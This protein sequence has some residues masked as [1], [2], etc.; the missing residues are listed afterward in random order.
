[1]NQPTLIQQAYRFALAP[2]PGQEGFLSACCGASRFWFNQ[3]LSLVKHRLEQ[4]AADQNVDVP[5][6]YQSLCVVFRGTAIKDH[7]APW[8]GEVVI[9]SYQ[10]GLEALGAA[11]RRF[12]EGRRA[13]RGVGF[14]RFR[15]KGR[16]HESVIFQQPRIL[17]ARHICLDKKRLGPIKTKE[18]LRKLTRLLARDERA[19]VVRATVQ[20]GG[21]GWVISFTV[22]RS[23]KLRRARRPT[24]AVGVDMGL[25][26]LATLSTGQVAP[27]SRPL[28]E[29]LV[30]LRRLQRRLDR[31]RRAANPGNY[32]PDGRIKPAR[33]AWAKSARMVRTEE[34]IRRL[35]ERVAN[36]RREQAHQLT[37]LLTREFGVIGVETLAVKNMLRNRR[38]ARHISDV[39]WGAILAQLA[40]KSSWSGGSILV[41]ADRFHPSSKTCSACGAVRAKLSLAERV[42]TCDD[43]AC[44]HVQDRDLNA[45]LNLAHMAARHAQ[46]E[47]LQCHVAATGAETRNARGGQVSLDPVEHSPAKREGPSGSSQRG[48]ALALA[49]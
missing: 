34:R 39:G 43:S 21:G 23:P 48:H 19:R 27:N 31:Q 7:V 12:S 1:M 44:G 9:G 8:R 32:L 24:A 41:A 37:T 3:G 26:R 22:E 2:T 15:A 45:A 20:R 36:L 17:D 35:H 29:V 16:C 46:A 18:S 30:R 10:A 47:G 14:P 25:A 40:Y 28:R 4:R 49:A 11:L 5:W 6:S 13:G 42:F 38:L 33:K